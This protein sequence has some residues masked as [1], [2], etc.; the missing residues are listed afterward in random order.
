[1]AAHSGT[2]FRVIDLYQNFRKVTRPAWPNTGL[3]RL[4]YVSARIRRVAATISNA[5]AVGFIFAK[6]QAA[7]FVICYAMWYA[8]NSRPTSL[9]QPLGTN[10]YPATSVDRQDLEGDLEAIMRWL[11]LTGLVLAMWGVS[12]LWPDI[13]KVLTAP[14]IMGLVLGLAA[15]VLVYILGQRH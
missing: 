4:N 7:K 5:F 1:M 12:L 2:F 10:V 11:K 3:A 14:V 13:N 9:A 6:S 8:I 15:A